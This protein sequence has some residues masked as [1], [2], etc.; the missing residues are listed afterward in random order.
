M[1]SNDDDYDDNTIIAK[2]TVFMGISIT[3]T[4]KEKSA[5]H[6]DVCDGGGRKMGECI[7]G[8]RDEGRGLDQ[9]LRIVQHCWNVKCKIFCMSFN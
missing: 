9:E 8:W 6:H 2:V 1:Y 4:G 7:Q 5:W 3:F